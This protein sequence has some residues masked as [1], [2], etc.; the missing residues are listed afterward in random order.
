MEHLR[1]HKIALGTP[2]AE[3]TSLKGKAH[4]VT[5]F[6]GLKRHFHREGVELD[7]VLYSSYDALVTAFVA[8]EVDLAWNG[9]LA[10]V[11]IRRALAE[12]CRVV[13]MRDIDVGYTTQSAA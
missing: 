7:W 10:Y 8:G 6:E 9:P 2:Y 13:A 12:P 4:L 5:I 1:V 11:K 3:D